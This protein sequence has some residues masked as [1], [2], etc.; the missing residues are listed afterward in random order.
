MILPEP[1][2]SPPVFSGVRITPS[3]VLCVCFVDPCLSF[4]SLCCL[5][6]FDLWILI[7]PLVSSNSSY[8]AVRKLTSYL[9]HLIK[10][11]FFSLSFAWKGSFCLPTSKGNN[12]FK[13]YNFRIKVGNVHFV[14]CNWV[15]TMWHIKLHCAYYL[16]ETLIYL[17]TSTNKTEKRLIKQLSKFSEI[18]VYIST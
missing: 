2:S 12:S 14:Y 13:K 1:L 7:T 10:N 15:F 9:V 5:F 8:I 18:D 16:L 4:W 6:F 3:S 11:M 17:S